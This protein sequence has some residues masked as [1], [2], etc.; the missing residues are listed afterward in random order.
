M[1]FVLQTHFSQLQATEERHLRKMLGKTERQDQESNNNNGNGYNP[2]QNMIELAQLSWF[3]H[4]V[5][6]GNDRMVWQAKT[7]A[8]GPK[9]LPRHTSKE[10]I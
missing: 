5:R 7:Q 3:G 1:T 9:E 8:K 2:P 6:M 4:L 10:M